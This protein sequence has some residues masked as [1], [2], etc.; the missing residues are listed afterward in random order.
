MATI[1]RK[2]VSSLVD[3]FVKKPKEFENY[4]KHCLNILKNY[5]WLKDHQFDDQISSYD[6]VTKSIQNHGVSHIYF[7]MLFDQYNKNVIEC[8]SEEKK[9]IIHSNIYYFNQVDGLIQRMMYG[10]NLL[11]GECADVKFNQLD[12]FVICNDDCFDYEKEY[13][14]NEIYHMVLDHKVIVLDCFT[15]DNY[16]LKSGIRENYFDG[17]R[18]YVVSNCCECLGFNSKMIDQFY[19][20]SGADEKKIW[21][22]I[23][24][25]FCVYFRKDIVNFDSDVECQIFKFNMNYDFYKTINHILEITN[26]LCKYYRKRKKSLPKIIE[27]TVFDNKRVIAD[28]KCQYEK[29]S[30]HTEL[31]KVYVLD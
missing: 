28:I 22:V 5:V 19:S 21:G 2:K 10:K 14:Y 15:S 1:S 26:E 27:K 13:S 30:N 18:F 24:E 29:V 12:F 7:E 3:D 25:P 31:G 20:F 4:S 9:K 6:Y 16:V 17:N 11:E 8:I 23:S